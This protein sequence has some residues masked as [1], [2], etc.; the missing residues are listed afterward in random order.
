[1][2]NIT[3]RTAQVVLSAGVALSGLALAAGTAQ[4]FN[5]QPDPPG[6]T[7]RSYTYVVTPNQLVSGVTVSG[8]GN[9][10]TPIG[11][12]PTGGN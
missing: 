6:K 8:L 3:K 1:M 11:P 10:P 2:N 9:S 12:A 7:A 5:P 4:A